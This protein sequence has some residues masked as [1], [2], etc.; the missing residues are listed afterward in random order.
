MAGR[1]LHPAGW[2]AVAGAWDPRTIFPDSLALAPFFPAIV[3]TWNFR[4]QS[5]HR[6]GEPCSLILHL[7]HSRAFLADWA[8]QLLL[9]WW[10]SRSGAAGRFASSSSRRHAEHPPT[11]NGTRRPRSTA[12]VCQS[13]PGAAPLTLPLA[14]AVNAS[15]AGAVPVDGSTTSPCP[16]T[17]FVSAPP[18]QADIILEPTST[19]TFRV[20]QVGNFG[21][22][23]RHVGAT[24]ALFL[25]VVTAY[26]WPCRPEETPA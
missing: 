11:P 20:V 4:L 15:C 3:I 17:L 2:F 19:R 16:F 21:H 1:G 22:R 26:T 25:L 24:A 12:R 5:G 7:I 8:E 6:R 23:I 9:N 10:S 14:A 18:T 13:R